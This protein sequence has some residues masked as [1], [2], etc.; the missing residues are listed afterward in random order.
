MK[1]LN[2][3]HILALLLLCFI[4]FK[5]LAKEVNSKD[6]QA[7]SLLN[8]TLEKSLK[9]TSSTF[10]PKIDDS[11][12]VRRAYLKII[13]RI[14]TPKEAKLFISYS[15]PNKRQALVSYLISSDGYV[16][17]SFNYWADLLRLQTTLRE[18]GLGWHLW[19]RD[20]IIKNQPYDQFV[21][22]MI[23]AEGHITENPATGYL[24]RDRGMLLDNVSNTARIFLG[25]QIGCAQCHDHPFDDITQREYYQFSAFF[26]GIS[27]NHKQSSEKLHSAM[28]LKNNRK[29]KGAENKKLNKAERRKLNYTLRPLR[30]NAITETPTNS[31]RLPKDYKYRDAK[32]RD[33]VKPA[34]L[35][36]P[37]V[38]NVNNENRREKVKKWLTSKENEYFTKTLANRLWARVFGRGLIHPLDDLTN[39]SDTAHPEVLKVLEQIT[40]DYDYDIRSILHVLYSSELFQRQ[41]NTL[42]STEQPYIFSAPLLERMSA[43]QLY[44]SLTTIEFGKLDNIHNEN[45][46]TKWNAFVDYIKSFDKISPKELIK[47]ADTSNKSDS[48]IKKIHQ[49]AKTLRLQAKKL[50]EQKKF[51]EAKKLQLRAQN[52]N[53]QQ[54]KL[55]NKNKA[56]SMQNIG[57]KTK[58]K[59]RLRSSEYPTP[60]SGKHLIRRFGGSD[61]STPSSSKSYASIPQALTMLN[62]EIARISMN[63]KSSLNKNLA[64]ISSPSER[65]EHLFLSIYSTLPT[66]KEQ[67]EFQKITEDESSYKALIRAM[68]STNRFL[69]IQ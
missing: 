2:H 25:Q 36:P 48:K 54:Q 20:S 11:T 41:T 55:R 56:L 67:Q 29:A 37:R 17:H 14:P 3:H 45:L 43:E 47:K 30:T 23:T 57:S 52:L 40:R 6:Q 22:D 10:S 46:E 49:E 60:F 19:L 61:R 33:I 62:G 7:I 64:K 27:Y 16:S 58:P 32:P 4:S 35:F 42:T 66:E 5:T 13:G 8:T 63:K 9:N 65:L 53:S 21:A 15:Q 59:Q 50:R 69:F 12:F 31:L 26:G 51:A 1:S 68:L 39:Q 18:S 34:A 24:L 28:K 44:D 38:N